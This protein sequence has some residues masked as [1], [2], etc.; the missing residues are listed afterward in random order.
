VAI[1][2][3]LLA[4]LL[5]TTAWAACGSETGDEQ[6]TSTTLARAAAMGF[7]D[8]DPARVVEAVNELQPLGKDAALER[9]D[10]AAAEDPQADAFGLF[11]VLRVLFEVPPEQ[12]FPPV[13]IGEPTVA[14]PP[15]SGPL[16]RFPIVLAQDV[17]LLA[18]RG[19]MLGGL[20][21]AVENHV[22]YFREHGTVREA[23]LSPEPAE[24][25]EAFLHQWRAAYGD[26][27]PAEG[28]A[29]VREQL[30]RMAGK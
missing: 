4:L 29:V 22:R 27:Y 5:A 12:G 19:Y 2:C 14:P 10:A 7:E 6:M 15:K 9:V 3:L 30:A 21:E 1:R 23:P 13:R 17:P 18:V 8:Y 24:A 25:E 20:A 16:P 11:W 26:D 28:P